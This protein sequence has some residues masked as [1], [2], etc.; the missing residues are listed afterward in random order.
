M[1]QGWIVHNKIKHVSGKNKVIIGDNI[2]TMSHIPP[3]NADLV[4]LVIQGARTSMCNIWELAGCKP[5]Y[6]L[7]QKTLVLS[8]VHIIH[9]FQPCLS[10]MTQFRWLEFRWFAIGDNLEFGMDK[11]WALFEC[12]TPL[13]DQWSKPKPKLRFRRH[14]ETDW[15]SKI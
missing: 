12:L 9:Q 5:H 3:K 14:F 10:V 7:D 6:K 13:K 4:Y 15:T 8:Q 11:T 2:F 1:I